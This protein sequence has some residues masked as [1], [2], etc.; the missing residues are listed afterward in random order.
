[1]PQATRELRARWDG[2]GF[3]KALDFLR[4]RGYRLTGDWCWVPPTNSPTIPEDEE[5]AIQFMI[6]E[7]D[8][9]GWIEMRD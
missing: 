6:E 2:P 4:E 1:M 7:W 8:Y 9:G 5:S 3:E